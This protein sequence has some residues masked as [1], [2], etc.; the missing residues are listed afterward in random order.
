MFTI[1]IKAKNGLFRAVLELATDKIRT[2]LEMEKRYNVPKE[3]G[4]YTLS[5]QRLVLGVIW[6][7]IAEHIPTTSSCCC[8]RCRASP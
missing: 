5:S 3:T 8:S 2:G 4:D 7:F 1:N 6:K